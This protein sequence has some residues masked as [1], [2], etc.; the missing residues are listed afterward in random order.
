MPVGPPN[1]VLHPRER[2]GRS[3]P[4]RSFCGRLKSGSKDTVLSWSP[5]T[6]HKN[7]FSPLRELHR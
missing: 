5:D 2:S 6:Q 7:S 1:S 3:H 4:K